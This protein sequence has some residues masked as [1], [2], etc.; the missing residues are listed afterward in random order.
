MHELL[1]IRHPFF[2]LSSENRWEMDCFNDSPLR[3]EDG[4][5]SIHIGSFSFPGLEILRYVFPQFQRFHQSS[6]DYVVVPCR[7]TQDDK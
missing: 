1:L 4:P 6:Y 3:P 2:L 5:K 7:R